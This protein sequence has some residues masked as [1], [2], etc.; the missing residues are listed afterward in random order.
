MSI[1]RCQT[2]QSHVTYEKKSLQCFISASLKHL[3]CVLPHL[4]CTS[5][6]N[7][8]QWLVLYKVKFYRHPLG[9]NPVI[10]ESRRLIN[11]LILFESS[12]S[13]HLTY[14]HIGFLSI[15]SLSLIVLILPRVPLRYLLCSTSCILISY[16]GIVNDV[17]GKCNLKVIKIF[18]TFC[19][20]VIDMFI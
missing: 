14:P 18:V 16:D 8:S 4:R 11:S 7:T 2:Q 19:S 17:D 9:K 1:L 6:E 12:S 20:F 5:K 3:F 10:S 13:L 15:E